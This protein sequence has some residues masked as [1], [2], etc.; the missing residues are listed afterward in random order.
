MRTAA[1]NASTPL[2][3]PSAGLG[4]SRRRRALVPRASAGLT[5][6]AAPPARDRN[7]DRATPSTRFRPSSDDLNT[8]RNPALDRSAGL[9][10]SRGVRR[11]IAMSGPGETDPD[12]ISG[13]R[14]GEDASAPVGRSRFAGHAVVTTKSRQDREFASFVTV[15]GHRVC[16]WRQ[17]RALG[18][19]GASPSGPVAVNPDKVATWHAGHRPSR[20]VTKSRKC[21]E[22]LGI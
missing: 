22:K 1:R 21:L 12:W 3:S 11:P 8:P 19:R 9:L 6:P 7:H 4:R 2:E 20:L 10:F 16:T 13:K 18:K 14:K 5:D 15:R 17:L